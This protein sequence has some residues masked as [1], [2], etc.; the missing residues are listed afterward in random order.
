MN[1]GEIVST[2]F[3]RAW[4]HKSLWLLGFLTMGVS[5]FNVGDRAGDWEEIGDFV[6]RH[7]LLILSI[8]A[9]VLILLL[10]FFILRIIAEGALIDAAARLHRSE[11]YRLGQSWQTGMARFWSMLGAA[12]LFLIMI[13]ALVLVLVIIGVVAFVIALAIGLLSLLLLIP[14]FLAGLYVWTITYML[15]QRMIVLERRPVMDSIG[16][17]FSWLSRTPGTTIIIFLIYLGII[18][19]AA[20]FAVLTLLVV[21]LPFIALGLFNFWLALLLGVPTGLLV[22]YLINGYLGS[23]I[24]LMMTGFYFRLQQHLYPEVAPAVPSSEPGPS[25]PDISIPPTTV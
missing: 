18:I 21:S 12:I 6:L 5:T 13:L 1:Y 11:P 22:L 2:A 10:V 19:A 8:A 24:S 9:F 14:I 4:Q 23:A 7:P 16:E 17:S 25:A 3:T 15:T 20:I